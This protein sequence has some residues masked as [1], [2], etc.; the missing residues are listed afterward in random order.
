MK[1]SK[2][3]HISSSQK[4]KKRN[5]KKKK[6]KKKK[7]VSTYEQLA[8]KVSTPHLSLSLNNKRDLF[9]FLVFLSHELVFSPLHLASYREASHFPHLSPSPALFLLYYIY[10]TQSHTYI[11]TERR[12][13]N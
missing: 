12:N 13:K 10:V 3:Y 8:L 9:P 11:H 7:K 5:R 6:K 2:I 4:N 1:I